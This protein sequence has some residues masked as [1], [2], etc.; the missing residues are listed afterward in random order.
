VDTLFM[1]L[2]TASQIL[3]CVTTTTV[4]VIEASLE[5]C[6]SSIL[7]NMT[8]GPA[9]LLLV[10]DSRVLVKPECE[11]WRRLTTTT[12]D[13]SSFARRLPNSRPSAASIRP[14]AVL[15]ADPPVLAVG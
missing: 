10:L 15:R 2:V 1:A 8:R 11:S 5:R 3:S 6:Y 13:A 4:C 14:V 9:T 7:L 12:A